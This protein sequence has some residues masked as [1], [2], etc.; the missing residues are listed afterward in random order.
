[1]D[2]ELLHYFIAENVIHMKIAY[3]I[4]TGKKNVHYLTYEK[5]KPK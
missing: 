5:K 3:Y 1:M 2:I 4:L